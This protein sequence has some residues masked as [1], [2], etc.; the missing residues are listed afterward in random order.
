MLYIYSFINLQCESSNTG[1]KPCPLKYAVAILKAYKASLFGYF[2]VFD[3]K[4]S[5]DK[6]RIFISE[7]SENSIQSTFI[8][9]NT[10]QYQ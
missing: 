6:H 5:V 1:T 9:I 10:S 2:V 8:T 3:K 4:L 7:T